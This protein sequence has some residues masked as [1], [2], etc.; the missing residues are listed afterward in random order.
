MLKRLRSAGARVA[1]LVSTGYIP[2]MVYG[3]SVVGMRPTELRIAR[4]IAHAAIYE[5]THGRS[6]DLDFAYEADGAD[7]AFR[8]PST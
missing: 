1:T 8:P 5:H 6:V 4:A 7:A 2:A 3:S